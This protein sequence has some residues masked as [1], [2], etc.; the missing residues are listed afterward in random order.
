MN[1]W[2]EEIVPSNVI[3]EY[4]TDFIRPGDKHLD[5]YYWNEDTKSCE[6]LIPLNDKYTPALYKIKDLAYAKS[7]FPNMKGHKGVVRQINKDG[8]EVQGV[9]F[10]EG[11]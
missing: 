8:E 6:P 11:R 10:F 4:P 5:A 1:E 2:H 7:K 3:V 9:V